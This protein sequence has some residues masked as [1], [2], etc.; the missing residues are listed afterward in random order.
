MTK[1]RLS[2]ILYRTSRTAR[3]VEAIESG[4]PKRIARRVKNRIVGR[5]LS[6]ILRGLWR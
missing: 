5:F 3:D 2:D 4:D 1:R 6:R